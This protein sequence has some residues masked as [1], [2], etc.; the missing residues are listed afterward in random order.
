M[1]KVK[2]IYRELPVAVRNFLLRALLLF[3]GWLLL[4]NLVLKPLNV[5]D[6]QLTEF[7]KWGTVKSLS[8]FYNNVSSEGQDILINGQTVVGIA[9]QC[10]GLELIVL[11]LGFLLCLPTSRRRAIT[12]AAAGTIL[13][14]LLNIARCSLLAVLFMNHAFYANFAHHYAFKL[15]VYG[16]VFWGWIIYSKHTGRHEPIQA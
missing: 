12:F 7:V 5:P 14:C 16:A 13:I 15:I 4:Y 2:K 8:L 6:R 9:N 10:N 1:I 3:A 11:Y